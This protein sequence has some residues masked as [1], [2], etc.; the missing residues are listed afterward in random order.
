MGRIPRYGSDSKTVFYQ[1]R[2]EI[3]PKP[4]IAADIWPKILSTLQI[5][6]EEKEDIL[7]E[8]GLPNLLNEITSNLVNYADFIPGIEG[9]YYL[10]EHLVSGKV[11][12]ET[13]QSRIESRAIFREDSD[14]IPTHW[15]LEYIEQD[16]RNWY[17]RW[18]TNVGITR[19]DNGAHAVN[20]RISIADD[21]AFLISQPRIPNRN[22]PRFVRAMLGIPECITLAGDTRLSRRELRLNARTFSAFLT[23]LTSAHR[24]VPFIVVSSFKD[25]RDAYAIDVTTMA[26]NL[27]GAAVVYALDL[28]DFAMRREYQRAFAYGTPAY[29]YR[30]DSGFARVYF[31][32]VDLNDEHGS[33][34]HHYYTPEK[35][36]G[37]R[38]GEIENDICGSLSRT[39]RKRPDEV[40]ELANIN[41]IVSK[42]KRK[43]AEEKLRELESRHQAAETIRTDSKPHEPTDDVAECSIR[44]ALDEALEEASFYKMYIE[45]LES[46]SAQDEAEEEIESLHEQVERLEEER[47]ELQQ[48]VSAQQYSLDALKE[49][50]SS[51]VALEQRDRVQAKA[52]RE[53][54][55]FP[56]SPYDSLLLAKQAFADTLVILEEAE[57]SAE[58]FDSGSAEEVFDILRAL[59]VDLWQ[60]YFGKDG[61]PQGDV[62]EAFRSK[63]GLALSF[64][65]SSQTNK[66]AKLKQLRERRYDGRIIDIS[67][68]V[69]GTSGTRKEKLRV[70]FAIDQKTRKI[71]I[72]HC[73]AHLET[74]GT[75]HVR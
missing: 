28:S 45:L 3:H 14:V 27:A 51:I 54:R 17:R 56:K 32:K 57:R 38:V 26:E 53:M 39:Y 49:S 30:V 55:A 63:T 22:T 64:T 73:G 44:K 25:D 33:N 61:T 2:F 40:L 69:K 43:A 1:A 46:S 21:P 71:V 7:N 10:S 42:T 75:R 15:A 52:L 34:R 29:N 16:S 12:G 4:G 11:I 18:Y 23:S 19:L 48:K 24:T 58:D 47:N 68:H 66:S 67:P 6:L 9:N 31:P 74:A 35:L 62:E 13:E 8:K 5:W 36:Q 59:S 72:G 60:M 70:H 20:V 50:K 65:E 37:T 41:T